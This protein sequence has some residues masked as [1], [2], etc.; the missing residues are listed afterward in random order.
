[1][2]NKPLVIT[3]AGIAAVATAIGVNIL[4]WQDEVVDRPVAPS[5][6]ASAPPSSGALAP[7]SSE[8]SA[9]P[10]PTED[11][12]RTSKEAPVGLSFDVVQ[13]G[14]SGDTVIAGRAEPGSTVVILDGGQV[15]GEVTA[16]ARGEWVFVPSKPL[17]PGSRQLSLEMRRPGSQPVTSDDVVVLVVPEREK[18]IAGRTAEGPTG[19][20]ALR[21]PRAGGAST[22]LQT[23][24]GKAGGRAAGLRVD[25]IDYDD[26]GRLS[27]SGRARPGALVNLYLDDAHIGRVISDANG[28]WRL[29]PE[30]RIT[31]GL[32]TLR[33]DELN[34]AGKVAARVLMPFSRAVTITDAPRESFVIVQPGNSLWRLARR[35]YGRGIRYTTIFEAND[36]QIKDP[37]L[38]YPGQ[39]FNLPATN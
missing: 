30:R 20:L 6:E 31:P 15:L 13:V 28:V 18:D 39:V 25:T 16:D 12:G 2:V 4:L 10:S 5:S 29:N 9:P 38:I 11:T 7:A 23:P 37:D 14:P 8:A 3:A 35:V 24:S 21:V 34:D 22:V 17:S 27:I 1:M 36:D 26:T 32:Y 19:A 33:A